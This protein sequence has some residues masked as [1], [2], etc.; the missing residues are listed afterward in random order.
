MLNRLQ[1]I[2]LIEFDLLDTSMR[3]SIITLGIIEWSL[4]PFILSFRVEVKK[5]NIARESDVNR[6]INSLAFL[7]ASHVVPFLR[8]LAYT[9]QS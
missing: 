8:Q 5:L 3:I 6:C 1:V 7:S 4:D 2:G 9:H